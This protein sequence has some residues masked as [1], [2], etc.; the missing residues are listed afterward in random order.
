MRGEIFMRKQ[1]Y[2]ELV[3]ISDDKFHRLCDEILEHYNSEYS[4]LDSHGMHLYKDKPVP[5]TPDSIK[6]FPDGSI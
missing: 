3:S 4:N 6:F 1:L 5:G 2:D